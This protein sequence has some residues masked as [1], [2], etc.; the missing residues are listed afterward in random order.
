MKHIH[1]KYSVLAVAVLLIT[2]ALPVHAQMSESQIVDE[3][4]NSITTGLPLL[5]SWQVL[6]T[7]GFV[8]NW[9]VDFLKEGNMI[10]PWFQI[11]LENR[12]WEN[13]KA[14]YEK[15]IAFAALHHLP[16]ALKSTQWEDRLIYSEWRNLPADQNPN[17]KNADGTF[18]PMLSPLGAVQPW[19][20]IGYFDT[21]QEVLKKI[22][23]LYPDPP[24]ILFYS[25][26]EAQIIKF[27]RLA[28]EDEWYREKYGTDETNLGLM[29]QVAQA[30]WDV[31][32]GKLI[33]GLR[34][35]LVNDTWKKNSRFIGYTDLDNLFGRGWEFSRN[36]ALGGTDYALHAWDGA[37]Y[38]A[39][40]DNWS[41]ESFFY[42]MSP[43]VHIGNQKFAI[44]EIHKFNPNFISEVSFWDGEYSKIKQYLGLGVP[45]T[46][47]SYLGWVR[48]VIWT[49]KPQ[50]VRDYRGSTKTREN[51]EGLFRVIAGAVNEVHTNPILR[52]FWLNGTLVVNPSKGHPYKNNIPPEYANA[53]RWFVLD[54]DVNQPTDGWYKDKSYAEN[55]INVFSLAHVIGTAPS[56]QWLLYVEA[57]VKDF[58]KVT[59]TIP[60]YKDV[61]VP[62]VSSGSFYVLDEAKNTVTPVAVQNSSDRVIRQ[63]PKD[64]VNFQ[65]TLNGSAQPVITWDDN[66]LEDQYTLERTQGVDDIRNATYVMVATLPANTTTFTDIDT[67][68]GKYKYR[69]RARNVDV[70]SDYALSN[71]ITVSG[72]G[73]PTAT[74]T[75]APTNSAPTITLTQGVYNV[76]IGEPLSVA[77]TAQDPDGDTIT[78]TIPN[79]STLLPGAIFR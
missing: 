18:R 22:Q 13:V 47:N 74:P 59:I 71:T 45:Y 75:P 64:I 2:S 37:S 29:A 11:N 68:S 53:E 63:I 3:I 38:R 7:D 73:V 19:Y 78:L 28:A 72:T 50:F 79:L 16:I 17:V 65:V 21:N 31:R 66:N 27:S 55:T 24:L 9:Q 34:A 69:L 4:R 26:N 40:T 67:L 43:Q 12:P 14:Y 5:G 36:R 58:D 35:G 33:E 62:A 6:G 23:E 49:Q 32:Y 60:G 48:Y 46:Y 20:D 52:N 57:T 44:D 15:G 41:A 61:I 30:G 8:P 70:F 39:Y 56:R 54:V 51:Y 42:V 76:R 10:L 77:V 1:S 25:N